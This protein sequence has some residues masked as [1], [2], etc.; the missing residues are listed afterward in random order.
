MQNVKPSADLSSS[1][2]FCGVTTLK[3][4]RI[5]Y[6]NLYFPH[7]RQDSTLSV[8]SSLSLLRTYSLAERPAKECSNCLY[9]RRGR[10]TWSSHCRSLRS[11]L[12][13]KIIW[14]FHVAEK[15]RDPTSPSRTVPQP[16]LR[17]ATM[18]D[19]PGDFDIERSS[20]LPTS[21]RVY[22]TGSA[23]MGSYSFHCDAWAH[24]PG[25]VR[26]KGPT[27]RVWTT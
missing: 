4:S 17:L 14:Q 21:F 16:G 27:K 10:P 1:A 13:S 22:I 12:L 20:I 23:R 25:R 11:F 5:C 19:M 26:V 6:S 2:C 7:T 18:T 9:P 24:K 3:R 8:G 15:D